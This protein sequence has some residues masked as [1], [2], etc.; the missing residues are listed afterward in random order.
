MDKKSLLS[1]SAIKRI[2]TDVKHIMK[3]P[4][5][6]NGI[7]YMHNEE[8]LYNGKALIIGPSDTPYYSGFY[9]FDIC[10]PTDYPFSPPKILFCTQGEGIRFNPNL[11]TNGKVCLSILN[12]WAGEQ[13]SSIQTLTSILLT[14]SS[15]L[16][17]NPLLNEP[18]VK[19]DHP[20]LNV[21]NDI[22]AYSN[23]K[24]SFLGIF[25]KKYLDTQFIQFYPIIEKIFHKN[26]EA[27]VLFC[28]KKA[29]ELAANSVFV[30]HIY[31]LNVHVN[32][33]QLIEELTTC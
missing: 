2:L 12:T 17:K 18:C 28:I 21:Y 31:R 27:L 33:H 20:D 19:E 10:F 8:N 30:L 9:F 13:W 1:N 14:I 4:L 24:I 26:R 25:N 16:S 29:G 32:Y 5:D 7:Y 23:I 6:D 11:Y 22:I 15:I 3:N